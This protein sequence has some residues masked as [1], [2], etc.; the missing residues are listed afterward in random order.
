MHVSERY[1]DSSLPA[2]FYV[3]VVNSPVLILKNT[4]C[5]AP[6]VDTGNRHWCAA[7]VAAVDLRHELQGRHPLQLREGAHHCHLL[8]G[9]MDS[10]QA[11]L[12]PLPPPPLQL[13]TTKIATSTTPPH[14][15]RPFFLKTKA[16][17]TQVGTWTVL[18]KHRGRGGAGVSGRVEGY[19]LRQGLHV[20]GLTPQVR[21]EMMRTG[22]DQDFTGSQRTG[23]VPAG[24][25]S[26]KTMFIFL[27]VLGRFFCVCVRLCFIFLF[28][29]CKKQIRMFVYCHEIGT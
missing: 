3:P 15:D 14:M 6:D 21:W 24:P 29:K 17:K 20:D 27:F 2:V 23:Q 10:T 25:A 16:K 19:S 28:F 11:H 5:P 9:H 13:P 12:R 26:G 22:S 1:R 7:H 4:V 18:T 8:I